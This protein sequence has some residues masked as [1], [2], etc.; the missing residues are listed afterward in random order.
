MTRRLRVDPQLCEAHALC[1]D[2]APEVFDLGEDIATCA[3]TPDES[4]WDD[5]EAAAAACPRQAILI[6]GN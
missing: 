5:I 6:E 1:V 3:E 2:L 4:F